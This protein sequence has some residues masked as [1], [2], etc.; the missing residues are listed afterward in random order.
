M[1]MP[2]RFVIRCLLYGLPVFAMLI[3]YGW[4]NARYFLAPHVTRTIAVI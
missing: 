1:P 2:I 4:L 3:V